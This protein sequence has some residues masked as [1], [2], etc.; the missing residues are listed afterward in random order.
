MIV[1][2]QIKLARFNG[3]YYQFKNMFA[4]VEEKKVAGCSYDVCLVYIHI[5]HMWC[6][7]RPGEEGEN[8]EQRD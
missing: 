5:F 1:K 8:I 6:Q 4:L 2:F 3:F 7:A